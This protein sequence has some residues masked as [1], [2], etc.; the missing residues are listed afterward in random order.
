MGK[1]LIIIIIALAAI[2]G[3][4]SVNM[5]KSDANMLVNSVDE[6]S[7]LQAKEIA[8][9]G[10]ELG[11]KKIYE[12]TTW[13]DGISR[14]SIGSGV[15]DLT[16]TNSTS[17][18]PSGPSAGTF[19]RELT[20][21]GTVSG[22]TY[23]IRTIINIPTTPGTPP[24]LDYALAS[25]GD[26][27]LLG[28]VDVLDV[29]GGATGVNSNIHTNSDLYVQGNTT[30]T[31]YGTYSGNS[32]LNPSEPSR[33]FHPYDVEAG[34][35]LVAESDP[36]SIPAYNPT[37]YR[38]AAT[39]II[40]GSTIFTGSETLGSEESPEIIFVDGN[41]TISGNFTGWA[42]FICTGSVT[43]TG[44]IS[45][46]AESP[47]SNQLG[48]I[49]AGDIDIGGNVDVEA[50]LFAGGNIEFNGNNELYGIATAKGQIDFRGNVNVRY[51]QASNNLT[52]PIWDYADVLRPVI[53]S[54]LE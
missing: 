45:L 54:Y 5:M 21:T 4:V 40:S 8:K 20:S 14:L 18:Y 48:I 15:L 46:D 7:R 6:R 50:Q 33:F 13:N 11:I 30:V 9:S 29:Q 51:R 31:G 44:N 41:I 49:A 42:V 53:V 25:D 36:V 16:V 12:D 24:F 47:L 17:L 22:Q 27:Q 23:T 37:D 52:G 43:I 10:I 28:T 34:Q 1:M 2:T 26:L 38:D 32:Y 39:Q 19:G 35:S 3:L